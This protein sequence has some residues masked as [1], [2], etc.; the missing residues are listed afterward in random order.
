MSGNTTLTLT[1][2]R[3]PLANRQLNHSL[4]YGIS[5]FD[6]LVDFPTQNASFPIY[7]RDD[8]MVEEQMS[9]ESSKVQKFVKGRG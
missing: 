7:T 3:S 6:S 1:L 2:P 9:V 4:G 8:E 5:S